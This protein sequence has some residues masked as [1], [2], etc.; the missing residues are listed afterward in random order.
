MP[1]LEVLTADAI[2]TILEKNNRDMQKDF[3]N[4]GFKRWQ[5]IYIDHK[6]LSDFED[7]YSN[8]SGDVCFESL[9]Y[10][11]ENVIETLFSDAPLAIEIRKVQTMSDAVFQKLARCLANSICYD[12]KL[13]QYKFSEANR[14]ELA[15]RKLVLHDDGTISNELNIASYDARAS[16]KLKKRTTSKS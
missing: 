3:L 9:R 13:P 1:K 5:L 15:R 4:K 7:L 6:S 16:A 2:K 8:H 12:V 11:D 10:I 14:R